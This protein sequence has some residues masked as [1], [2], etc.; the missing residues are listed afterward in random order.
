MIMF[1]LPSVMSSDRRSYSKF[2]KFL[3]SEG[4]VIMQESIYTKLLLN[5]TAAILM[6]DKI[7]KNSPKKGLV[8]MLIITEKQF[9]NIQNI[10]GE[11]NSDVVQSVNRIIFI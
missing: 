2:M 8:Q 5:N 7:R 10:S 6:Q 4:F 11:V 1:D 9:S 3:R